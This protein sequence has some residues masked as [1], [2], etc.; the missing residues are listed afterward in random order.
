MIVGR[1]AQCVLQDREDVLHVLIYA[2]WA[3]RV[4]RVRARL[5]ASQDVEELTRMTDHERASLYTDL[6][7][8]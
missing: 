3:E 6:L 5:K 8:M 7:R 4:E 2:P 1:G